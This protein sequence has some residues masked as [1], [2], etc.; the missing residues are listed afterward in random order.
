MKDVMNDRGVESIDKNNVEKM[1]MFLYYDRISIIK[2]E[3]KRGHSF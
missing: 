1:K 3:Q 2:K